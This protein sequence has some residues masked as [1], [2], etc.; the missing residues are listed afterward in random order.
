V[1]FSSGSRYW[2]FSGV[3][4]VA[5]SRL[6]QAPVLQ[7]NSYAEDGTLTE[8]GAWGLQPEGSWLRVES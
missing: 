7:V 4:S 1:A 5:L 2:L 3:V 8:T 6:R